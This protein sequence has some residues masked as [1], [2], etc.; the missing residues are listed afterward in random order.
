M[1]AV[2][3]LLADDEDVK[4]P[5][6]LKGAF[7]VL[8]RGLKESPELRAGLGFTVI[9]SLGVTVASLVTP[10]LV[11]QIFDKGFT[12]TFNA[13]F[14]YG[15]CAAAFL[16][17][18]LAFLAARS[19]GRRLVTASENALMH[20]RVRTF[21]HIHALSI[22]EQSEEKRGVFVARVTA[23][24]DALQ[25]F[26]EWGGIAWIISGAQAIGAL[27]LMLYYSWQLATAIIVL[28][29]PLLIVVWSM[30]ARLSA[31][32]NAARTRVGEML[33]E[34]SESVMGAA[35]VRA[36]GLDEQTHDKV[37]HAISERY[38]A[39][40]L[41]HFRAATFWPMSSIFYAVALSTVIVL[42]SV[43]GRSWGLTFG[44]VSAFLFLADVFLHVF[45]DLPEIYS[46]TQTAIAGWRK[47]L[48]VLDLDIEVVEPA[49]G[50][51]LP[52]G[53]LSVE[54]EDVRFAYREGPEVLHG[55]TLS[56]PAGGHVAIVG[57]TGCGKTT[58]A[59]LMSRLADPVSGRIVIGGV[60]LRDVQSDSR[61]TRIR[62]VPQDGFLFGTTVRE[63]VRYGRPAATDTEVEAAFVELGLSDW[64]A[65]LP[66]GL[67]TPVGERGEALSVGE[68]QLVALARAQIGDPGLLI[69]DEATSAVDPATERRITEALRRLSAG[70]TVV[71]IAHRL[72]TA[73]G[74][75]R[76]F[77][78]DAGRLVQEGTHG[79]LVTAGGRYAALYRSWLGNV[80][81]DGAA[82]EG[83]PARTRS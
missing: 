31:A 77:V 29:I 55:I 2:A 26:M 62:M 43:Y 14:V 4:V 11:Q 74:A 82:P 6:H 30:Q 45:T 83:A 39:E 44:Q 60:D 36:Y 51:L 81:D 57:E 54:T 75:Q 1:S 72:S 13:R 73:E 80:R 61:R 23:D 59:K 25:E 7:A 65:G 20:L 35:V 79:E 69:L 15:R 47:I 37:E 34:V 68:R 41:A 49:N 76:V 64:V 50:V 33:S 42:G 58:F 70:R 28:L 66:D 46:E 5:E 24:V 3:E 56:V 71:T 53:P 48:A 8:R 18:V 17:V 22:A 27:L 63:N 10:V 12:P 32:F 16:L 67:A 19:A 21:R 78:F 40:V 9:V 38:K 52:G